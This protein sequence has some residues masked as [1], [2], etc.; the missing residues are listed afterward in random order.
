MGVAQQDDINLN[1]LT[2][3]LTEY[4]ME[5]GFSLHYLKEKW[6]CSGTEVVDKLIDIVQK[7]QKLDHEV[8]LKYLNFA[9]IIA[10]NIDYKKGIVRTLTYTGSHYWYRSEYEK[11]TDY[12]K[13]ALSITDKTDKEQEALINRGL[14][15]SYLCLGKLEEALSCYDM[16][17]EIYR[18]S[19]NMGAYGSICNNIGIV[20]KEKGE[21]E[22]A[23]SYYLESLEIKE[24]TD[25]LKA[26]AN[27]YINVG[28]LYMMQENYKD[29]FR[30]LEKVLE[31]PQHELGEAIYSNVHNNLGQ[32]YVGL[33]NYTKAL[34]H[35]E[36]ALKIKKRIKD[37]RGATLSYQEIGKIMFL[38]NRYDE[39]ITA[40]TKALELSREINSL[41]Y[42]ADFLYLLG[43]VNYK[44]GKIKVAEEYLIQCY[45][46]Q[47]TLDSKQPLLITCQLLADL[48]YE[49][50]DFAKSCDY[51]RLLVKT[52]KEISSEEK[53]RLLAEM[54]TRFE[55]QQR[56]STIEALNIKQEM[57][58]KANEELELFAGK[59]AHDMKEPMRMMSSFSSLLVRQ[60]NDKLDDTGREFLNH[61]SDGAKRMERLLSDMLTFARSGGNLKE[62]EPVNL[63]D[64]LYIVKTNLQMVIKETEAE[65]KSEQLP[66]VQAVNIAMIQLFQ[67][68]IA[69]A[70]KFRKPDCKPIV[71]IKVAPYKEG[72]HHISVSDNGI[73]IR[74]GYESKVF[75][76]FQR[77]NAKHE[78]DG[79]G[80]GLATCKKIVECLGGKIWLESEEG[81]GTTF[82]FLLPK[83]S[84]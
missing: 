62:T 52:E 81:V 28:I 2:K 71:E 79:S 37:R 56:D 31:I 5:Q 60:Y 51:M 55:V 53:S 35:I 39:A 25:D 69:N 41:S 18:Q 21:Y 54:Q 66:N 1:A 73:G 68:I 10:E 38:T 48:Y 47:K 3:M 20:Y 34:D 29:A 42:E 50:E 44:M 65:I 12:F 40:Y 33:G 24:N 59:A 15:N 49:K 61:I 9:K 27:T 70:I 8:A 16:A 76:I 23:L 72:F 46:I 4:D 36:F 22:K 45:D 82:H 74:K 75:I 7:G 58:T 14:G 83:T 77:L 64:I 63:N 78:Y 80:I 11:S 6:S 26:I 67:N 30:Y 19:Q 57:L 84:E 17:L 32:I 13:S 43:E